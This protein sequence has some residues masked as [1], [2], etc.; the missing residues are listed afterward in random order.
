MHRLPGD[1]VRDAKCDGFTVP[2]PILEPEAA[3]SR[4]GYDVGRVDV[5]GSLREAAGVPGVAGEHAGWIKPGIVACALLADGVPAAE[6]KYKIRMPD[7]ALV[8]FFGALNATEYEVF[9]EVVV[10]IAD[11][12]PPA[13]CR[14]D[15]DV[16][17]VSQVALIERE[18]QVWLARQIES[19]NHP[20]CLG[21]R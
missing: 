19:T 15:S 13:A 14:Q 5:D 18:H 3:L 12:D 1:E 21:A 20:L 7:G 4:S 6:E 16:A 9:R 8:L 10:P 17:G 11:Q 2:V